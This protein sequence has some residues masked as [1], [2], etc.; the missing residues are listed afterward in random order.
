MYYDGS[1]GGGIFVLAKNIQNSSNVE[2][3]ISFGFDSSNF[4]STHI[5]TIRDP[6]TNARFENYKN[7]NNCSAYSHYMDSTV[8]HSGV[9][10]LTRYDLPNGIIS[11]TFEFTL[12][13]PG[14]ETITVTNG[15]FDIKL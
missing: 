9:V 13:K 15:R 8:V 5:I 4:K 12:T 10:N 6:S 11:G 3:T 14:C 7:V 1:G 2:Q